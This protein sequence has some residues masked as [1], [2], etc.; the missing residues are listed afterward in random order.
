MLSLFF[1]ALGHEWRLLWRSRHDASLSLLFFGLVIVLFPLALGHTEPGLLQKVAPGM[2]WVA[3]LLASFLSLPM[4]FVREKQQGQLEALFLS[5]EPP[6]IWVLAKLLAHWLA[7]GLPLVVLAPVA[8]LLFDLPAH[9]G[10]VLSLSLLLGSPVFI[11][12]GAVGAALTLGLRQSGSLLALLVFPLY[13]PT[14]IFGSGAVQ[15]VLSGEGAG[16]HLQLLL[17]L[18]LGSLALAPWACTAALRLTLED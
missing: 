2:V 6:V 18:F 4:L 16:L 3:A 14:L 8:V 17:A 7:T 13:V 11:L 9:A 5:P 15:A 10:P 12:L 1:T